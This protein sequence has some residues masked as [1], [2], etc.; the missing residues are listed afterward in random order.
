MDKIYL[1]GE[2]GPNHNGSIETA[3]TMI[4]KMA[5]A[6]VDCVKFQMTD[7]YLLYS[8]DSFK[9]SYQKK[10]DKAKG[11]REMSLSYQLKRE[12]HIPL[13]EKCKEY[14]I[15]YVCSAF[16]LESLL[17][18]DEHFNMPYYKIASGEIF[19]L[20][21]I[22]YISEQS[23]PIIL[24]TGMA[25]YEEV[26]K[27]LALL[28]RHSQKDITVLHCISNYPAKYEEVHHVYTL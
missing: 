12:A 7:P 22:N 21:M 14:G 4:E 20:D 25:T 6:G 28:N 16:D 1:I 10:N 9:A 27:A 18:L 3:L 24:S 11:V 5:E 8:D 26:E 2:V 19:S 17:Y 13:Y 23:K 15:D